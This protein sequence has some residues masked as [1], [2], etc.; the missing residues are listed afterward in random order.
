MIR[1]QWR[2]VHGLRP[3][4]KTHKRVRNEDLALLKE[5][6]DANIIAE[7]KETRT[8]SVER[9]AASADMSHESSAIGAI[10]EKLETRSTINEHA[11]TPEKHMQN[12]DRD[13]PNDR[14]DARPTKTA[15][16]VNGPT[17]DK[18]QRAMYVLTHL[19]KQIAFGLS[20]HEHTQ[21]RTNYLTAECAWSTG[22]SRCLR[23][24]RQRSPSKRCRAR[25]RP[26]L[27][28]RPTDRSRDNRIVAARRAESFSHWRPIEQLL[29][30]LHL[31][32]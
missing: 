8:E 6:P 17:L 32:R 18:R 20:A 12:T 29:Q 1:K 16:A 26:I 2:S 5:A 10:A 30:I 3:H 21:Q 13:R 24:T 11:H 14:A 22:Q 27:V 7:E 23:R 25:A 31:Q 4:H 15:L 19:R 9:A 28:V